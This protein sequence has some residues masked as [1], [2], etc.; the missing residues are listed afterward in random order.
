MQLVTFPAS[1]P[2]MAARG[3]LS[4]AES[5]GGVGFS[6]LITITLR[7]EDL[8][9]LVKILGDSHMWNRERPAW[10]A[11]P[12]GSKWYLCTAHSRGPYSWK[13][14]TR[15]IRVV[16]G[17]LPRWRTSWKCCYCVSQPFQNIFILRALQAVNHEIRVGQLVLAT[18]ANNSWAL[19]Q[20]MTAWY[21]ISVINFPYA[22]RNVGSIQV[23]V[24]KLI[25]LSGLVRIL[26]W[27]F[28]MAYGASLPPCL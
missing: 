16:G 10:G 13:E 3:F 12:V 27:V 24:I 14:I 1:V 19:G 11:L 22:S 7:S 25:K 2:G 4:A 17:R 26:L 5:S 18:F 9:T 20:A 6:K 28:L 21:Q 15:V 8:S 23:R